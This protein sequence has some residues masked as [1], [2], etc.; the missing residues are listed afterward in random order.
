VANRIGFAFPMNTAGS[1]PPFGPAMH[2]LIAELYP[3]PRSIT[4]DGVRQTLR[5]LQSVAPLTIHE[6]PTG[7]PV[8]DW[9]VPNEWNVRQAHVTD[10]R[11]GRRVV[12][13]ADH[14]LHL[15][16]YST[17][18]RQR[19]T[20][21]DL[22]PHLHTLP[23]QPD[24]IPYRTSYYKPTWGFCLTHRALE[25]LSADT[26][27]DVVIDATLAPGHLTYG[28][29]LI[30]GDTANE[31]LFSAHTCH[32]QLANDNL[33]GVVVAAHLARHLAAGPRGRHSFRFVWAP[34]TIGAI[35]WLARNEPATANIRH[36]LILSNLGD[37]RTFTYKRS[38]RG[39]APVD[40]AVTEILRATGRPH[41]VLD[42][43]P[44]GYDERQYCS[45]GFNLPVGLLSNSQ[46]GTFPEYHTS[47]DDLSLVKPDALEASFR[48]IQDVVDRLDTSFSRDPKGELQ[49]TPEASASAT[50]HSPRYF[51][52][53]PKCE[54][55]LGRR[56]LFSMVGG[57]TSPKRFELALLWVLNQSDGGPTLA[58]IATRSAL[59][60]DVLTDAARALEA[61]GLLRR[62]D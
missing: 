33:S 24:R 34:G 13:F 44:Y 50:A 19:M 31:I 46:Y 3:L 10:A 17:P 57:R 12:D 42:F 2:A 4:G 16:G 14:A 45:P 1:Q 38:R 27:Y 58:E 41:T 55:Q 56:G 48:L 60:I 6:V 51:N 25:S 36:G 59:P 29:L 11:T 52:L 54:P 37:G 40:R 32:P 30:P 61:A 5:A 15:V 8:F 47:A 22:R 35:T 23:E 62:I 53:L 18:V 7:T 49:A 43:S 26:E 20:L 21:A 9:T 28:E 39:D